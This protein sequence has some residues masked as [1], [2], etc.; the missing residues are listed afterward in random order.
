MEASL[1]FSS[2]PVRSQR[3]TILVGSRKDW[4]EYLQKRLGKV[5]SAP[6][7]SVVIEKIIESPADPELSDLRKGKTPPTI[8]GFTPL[9]L[10]LPAVTGPTSS[11]VQEGTTI[12]PTI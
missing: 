1:Y 9:V 6:P 5:T 3:N 8:K 11:S 10:V 2:Y 7:L 4:D 12:V